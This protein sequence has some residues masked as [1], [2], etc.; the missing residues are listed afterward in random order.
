[1][2]SVYVINGVQKDLS[3]ACRWY[4]KAAAQGHEALHF[5]LRMHIMRAKVLNKTINKLYDGFDWL[6]KKAKTLPY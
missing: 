4:E 2:C 3:E 6:Q 1:M 5:R